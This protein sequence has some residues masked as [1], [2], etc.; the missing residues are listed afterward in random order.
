M[1]LWQKTGSNNMK[2]NYFLL[3][4]FGIL[5]IPTSLLA[6]TE[7]EDIALVSN[8]FQENYYESL[9][10]KGIENYDKA[11]IAL[12]KCLAL[13]PNNPVVFFEMGK[14]YLAQK[15]TKM[16]MTILKR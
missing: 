14:N 3:F 9:K 6:Q 10:Q 12:E 13:E 15:N 8:E 4:L 5:V 2:N 11:I 1:N 7:P 16:P